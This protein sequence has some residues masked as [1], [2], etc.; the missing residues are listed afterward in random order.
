[1]KDSSLL[2]SS[3]FDI[4][5]HGEQCRSVHCMQ[6]Y[7]ALYIVQY[8]G[9]RRSSTRAFMVPIFNVHEMRSGYQPRK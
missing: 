8:H 9:S 2:H 3:T 5:E 4:D 7:R 6:S 1:M